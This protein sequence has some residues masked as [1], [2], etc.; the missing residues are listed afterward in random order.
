MTLQDLLIYLPRFVLTSILILL[1]FSVDLIMIIWFERKLIGRIHHR[2]SITETGPFGLLQNIAD[3]IKLMIKEDL[4]PKKANRII[5]DLTPPLIAFSGILPLALIP[6]SSEIYVSNPENSLLLVLAI[7]SISPFFVLLAGIG[8]GSKYPVIGGFR[9]ALQMV[10]YEIPLV[11][12]ALGVVMLSGTFNLMEIVRSQ[13]ENTWYLFLQPLGFFIFLSSSIMENER[14]PFDIPEAESELVAGWRTEFSSIKFG[15]IM[16]SEYMKMFVNSA[17]VTL[18][19]L[20]GWDGPLLPEIFWFLLKVHLIIFL[21]IW[22]RVTL[23]RLRMDQLLKLSWNYLIPLSLLNLL[24]T[25][26]E[27]VMIGA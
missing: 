20:G 18:L 1:I 19:Y 5:H 13:V 17:L 14:S 8:S 2:R 10:S 7:C 11:L 15:L 9:A 4:I 6:F 27:K 22:I 26:V 3:F 12:S 24:L 23:M 21:F 25:I 16:G